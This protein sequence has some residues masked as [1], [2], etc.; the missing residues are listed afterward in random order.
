MSAK[1]EMQPASVIKLKLGL[2]NG[3]PVHK[4]FTNTCALHMDKYVPMDEGTLA[5]TVVVNSTTTSNVTTDEIIYDTPYA[6]YMYEGVVYVDPVY[7]VA[8]FPI[9]DKEGNLQGFYSRKNVTKIPSSRQ[10]DYSDEKHTEA[11]PHW[12]KRMWSA[13]KDTVVKEVEDYMWRNAKDGL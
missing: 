13:E 6:H 2:E 5:E 3:G 4:F 8:A 7:G 12:D 10:I 11:G 1:L 9:I